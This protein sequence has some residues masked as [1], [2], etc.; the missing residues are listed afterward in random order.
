MNQKNILVLNCGSS[1]L[2]FAVIEPHSQHVIIHGL[3][4][5]LNTNNARIQYELPSQPKPLQ[6]QIDGACH[7]EAIES[8]LAILKQQQLLENLTGVGHRVVHGG[9]AYRESVLLNSDNIESLEKLHHLAPLHNPVNL[10][11]IKAINTLLP[12]LPQVAVFDTAFHQTLPEAAYLYGIPLEFYQQHGVRRYGFHGT[13]YR[14]VSQKAAQLIKKPLQQCHFLIAHLG[15]G[16]S[17]CAIK[18]GQSVDTSMGLTPLEGLVMGTRSGDVDPGLIDFLCQRLNMDMA[19]VLDILNKKSGLLGI[20]GISNDM[21]E[22]Q[23]AAQQGDQRANLAVE[24]F[25]FKVARYLGAL[26]V[27]LPSIDALIFTGGIGEND[28][29]TRSLVLEHLAI[30]G[31]ELDGKLNQKNGDPLG[32]IS[33]QHS[34]LA[35]VVA[36]NEELMIAMDTHALVAD[37]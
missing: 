26:A 3:A 9:E 22:T 7:D 20:S 19:G 16:C 5:R 32:R 27:S 10:L 11:G 37:L 4:E 25:A 30:L 35:M 33:D 17:A 1:S 28:R 36:T 2:K 15:N 13:S 23:E 12:Q 21:R 34:T 24:L 29:L 6:V 18:N 31:F 14:Y 8:V